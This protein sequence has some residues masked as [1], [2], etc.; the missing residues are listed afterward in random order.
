MKSTLSVLALAALAVAQQPAPGHCDP[1]YECH[2][3]HVDTRDV[4]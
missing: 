4:V 2:Y 1:D 3:H